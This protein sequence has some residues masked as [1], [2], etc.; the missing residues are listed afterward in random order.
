MLK[1]QI[2]MIENLMVVYILQAL[3]ILTHKT[4]I[5]NEVFTY[6]HKYVVW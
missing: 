5:R 3:H 2:I 1:K 6:S 4:I